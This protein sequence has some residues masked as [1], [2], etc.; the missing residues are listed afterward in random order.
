MVQTKKQPLLSEVC[1]VGCGGRLRDDWLSLFP[2]LH[3]VLL[4]DY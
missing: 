3:L 1:G 4:P 2:A